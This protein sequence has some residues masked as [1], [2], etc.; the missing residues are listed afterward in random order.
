MVTGRL[1]DGYRTA[2][3]GPLHPYLHPR[4]ASTPYPAPSNC[5]PLAPPYTRPSAR[6]SI[7]IHHPPQE[8]EDKKA[9]RAQDSNDNEAALADMKLNTQARTDDGD[10]LSK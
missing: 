8:G 3:P 5:P 4:A 2:P 6:P 1:Q 9:Q 10:G 7:P